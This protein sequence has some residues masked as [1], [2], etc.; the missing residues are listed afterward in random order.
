MVDP[1]KRWSGSIGVIG[2]VL[3]TLLSMFIAWVAMVLVSLYLYGD[4]SSQWILLPVLVGIVEVMA[5]PLA[6]ALVLVLRYGKTSASSTLMFVHALLVLVFV[7]LGACVLG[8]DNDL[9]EGSLL[10]IGVH[11]VL[12]LGIAWTDSAVAPTK[13]E[14]M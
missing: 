2:L 11:A 6:I 4:V 13:D 7:L 8:S 12:L 1:L 10:P 14:S 5:A 9:G 3:V